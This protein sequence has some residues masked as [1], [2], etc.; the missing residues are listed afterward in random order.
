MILREF[1]WNIV[2]RVLVIATIALALAY[3]L[4]NKSWFFTPLVLT[5]LLVISVWSL[6]YYIE[7][8]NKD[9]T[10]FILS[11]KQ[12]EFTTTFPPGR[13][14]RVY[15]KLSEAF[16]DVI[17][18]FRKINLQKE[19][20]Y[21]YLQLLTENI[22]AGIICYDIDGKIESIN[23]AAKQLLNIFQLANV[24]DL[25]RIN[26]K[27]HTTV[28]ELLPGQKQLIR[29]LLAE[30]E[31]RLSVQMRELIMDEKPLKI[32]FLQDLNAELE[33][34]EVEAW[35]KLTRVLTHEIMNSVTPIVSL[36][37]A[38]NTLLT[39]AEGDRKELEKLDD[40]DRDD[41]YDSLQTIQN[42]SKGL[43][44]FVNA[45]KDFTKNPDLTIRSIDV[46]ELISRVCDLLKA[47]L[48]SRQVILEKSL[49]NQRIIAQADSEWMEQVLLNILKN[50]VEALEGRSNGKIRI[51]AEQ[52]QKRT[53]LVISD[54]GHGMDSE[55]L[56]QVFV[57]FF[58]T[59][60][61][62]TGIGLSL[63]R[64]IIK[65]HKGA[66]TIS[67]KPGEGTQVEVSW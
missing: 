45:Y 60:K 11:I 43:L 9:L 67:S 38:V 40:D 52:H 59:K 20:H 5:L 61:K 58:T 18:E 50:S 46:G 27:L 21:Q 66:L 37:E 17:E 54:N 23:P 29:V 15:K 49:P 26:G 10:H 31:Y 12:S 35:Q 53:S 28:K 34:H 42:R 14:G 39:T 19:K 48:N 62:G 47:E 6:I 3:V 8:T 55:T 64:Q 36:T 44:R 24:N 7:R 65:M 22:Q 4:T 25:E 1:R 33:D 51:V 57:P 32:I 13:R 63:S 16:N 30:K 41:L 2:L 56:D